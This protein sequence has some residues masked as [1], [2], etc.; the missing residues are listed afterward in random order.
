MAFPWQVSKVANAIE[1]LRL[2]GVPEADVLEI[3]R[4]L[5]DITRETPSSQ[6]AVLRVR[7]KLEKVGKPLYDIGIKVIGDIAASAAKAQLG[8]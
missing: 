3:E 1:L 6:A 7:K 4:N 2:E 8:L 5:P